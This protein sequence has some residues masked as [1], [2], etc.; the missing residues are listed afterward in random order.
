V[1]QLLERAGGVVSCAK[2]AKSWRGSHGGFPSSQAKSLTDLCQYC[3]DRAERRQVEVHP[4]FV[5]FDPY[6]HLEQREDDRLGLSLCQRCALQS[7][8]AQLLV[9]HVGC[10]RQQ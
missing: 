4:I 10:R 7:Q 2:R 8:L 3:F 5:L 6:G 9:Q 1:S